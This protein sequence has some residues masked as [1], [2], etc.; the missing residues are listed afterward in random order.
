MTEAAQPPAKK[1]WP[2]PARLA[3]M[4]GRAY[5]IAGVILFVIQGWLLYHPTKDIGRDPSALDL[6]FE[7]FFVDTSKG[8]THGWLIKAENARGTVLF[9]HGNAGNI[10]DRIE[11]FQL[12]EPNQLN[13]VMYDYGGYGKSEGRPHEQRLYEDVRAVWQ[14]LT[15]EKGI[16]PERIIIMGRSLGGGPSTQLATEVGAAGLILESTF[17]SIADIAFDLI[18]IFPMSLLVRHEYDNKAKIAAIG[19]PVMFFHSP[20]DELVRFHHGKALFEAAKE[21]KR[22]VELQGGHNENWYVSIT[23][24]I[25]GIGR[26]ADEVLPQTEP[27]DSGEPAAS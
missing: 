11:L 7:E 3:L 26:F 10:A 12:F 20:D 14:W 16:P 23:S 9:S 27:G 17:T 1:Q 19:M 25:A 22:F 8:K 24:Y 21:P 18:P 5:I 2:L 13:L 15:E 6:P 4:A